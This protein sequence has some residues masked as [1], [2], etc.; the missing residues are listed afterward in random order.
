MPQGYF[1]TG[2]DTGVGKTWVAAALMRHLSLHGQTVAG[3]KPVA[4]GCFLV[5]G[6]LQNEDALML[7]KQCSMPLGYQQINPYA[8]ALAVSPHIAGT[9]N[10]VDLGVIKAAFNA[11]Q[12]LV[13]KVIVEGAGG[14]YSPLSNT[15]DNADL[16]RM[17]NLPVILVVAIR[18]GCI[19][20]ARLSLQAIKQ[21]GI[22][23]AGWIATCID[24]ELPARQETLDFLAG[25]LDVPLL[26]VMPYVVEQDVNL[27]AA[28]I[29]LK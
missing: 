28:L 23:C 7:Q 3:M 6:Q 12:A 5:N 27:L 22:G 15:I 25:D 9:D 1:I 11:L 17:L 4:S 24:P 13:D 14:W 19:N 29:T 2:T 8:Y 20:Q 10:P 18:L 26:G 21:S 16:A